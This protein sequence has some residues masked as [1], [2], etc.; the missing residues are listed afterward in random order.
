MTR[1]FVAGA[2][3]FALAASGAGAQGNLSTQGFGYPPGQLSTTAMSLGGG[4][5]E[6]DPNSAVNPAAAALW[7]ATVM[8]MQYEPEVRTV[9]RLEASSRTTTAR[10]PMVG[11]SLTLGRRL[12][13]Q[14]T[15]STFLDR[16]WSSV[17]ETQ[18]DI[19]GTVVDATE[20]FSSN[21]GITDFRLALAYSA[22]PRFQIGLGGHV[23]SGENR[24]AVEQ[25]F[26][27]TVTF[28]GTS[29]TSDI[30][31]SAFGASAGV[32]WRPVASLGLGA[33]VRVGGDMETQ[34]GDSVLTSG[35]LP[36]RYGFGASYSGISGVALSARA[37]F[38]E[39]SAMQP[40]RRAG[41]NM[42]AFDSWDYGVGADVA[43]PTIGR[44]NVA[45]RLGARY[46]GLPFGA[47]GALGGEQSKVNEL[48][49]SGGFGIPLG[50]GRSRLDVGVAR[51]I[52]DL[53]A[54]VSVNPATE[55]AYI[56]S[57]GVR[58]RP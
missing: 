48:T 50:I 25:R 33:S 19:G 34:T 51:A 5:A 26:P 38:D 13:A 44:R 27:D 4:P 7:G 41:S 24:I 55:T 49:F 43:G 12:T 6:I 54:K 18:Q 30:S 29:Q 57:F 32:V 46:R 8:F 39:W 52:R 16:T 42:L 31:Y 40:L 10:F 53:D 2:L 1:S 21:G 11:M 3:I 37:S 9:K 36:L 28:S 35:K 23:L 45:L 20:F 14:V 58:V 22:S 56:F 17:T 47:G 15:A